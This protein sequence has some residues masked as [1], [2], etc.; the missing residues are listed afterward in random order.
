MVMSMNNVHEAIQAWL[1]ATR[2]D[3]SEPADATLR[4]RWF[5]STRAVLEAESAYLVLCRIETDP[6]ARG[7]GQASELLEW[8][9]AVCDKYGVTLLGQATVDNAEGLD[10]DALLAWYS[11][12]GFEIDK[13][14]Q[15][16]P[17]VWYPARPAIND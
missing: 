10:Q 3:E 16:Q 9:K 17:L 5:G 1:A 2:A 7:Q 12:H 11:R 4:Y 15:G 8:L 13:R 6:N 14:P